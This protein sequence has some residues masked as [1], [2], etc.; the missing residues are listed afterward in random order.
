M[1]KEQKL[2]KAF[3]ELICNC[4]DR[5]GLPKKPTLKQIKKAYASLNEYVKKCKLDEL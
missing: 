5:V 1:T 4:V 3:N 2:V